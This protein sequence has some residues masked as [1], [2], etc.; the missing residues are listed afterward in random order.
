MGK[1]DQSYIL[2][3]LIHELNEEQNIINVF[4]LNLPEGFQSIPTYDFE[5]VQKRLAELRVNGK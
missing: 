3:D 4:G 5:F 1:T 2:D